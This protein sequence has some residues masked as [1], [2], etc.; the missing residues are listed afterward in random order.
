MQPTP[1]SNVQ[2][3]A[4]LAYD[5]IERVIHDREIRTRKSEKETTLNAKLNLLFNGWLLAGL[6]S[7]SIPIHAANGS[8]LSASEE[9]A[10][11]IGMSTSEVQ[12][13]LGRP[14]HAV[15]YG[16]APGPVWTYYVLGAPFG[17]T[18]FNIDF[19]PDGRVI[20]TSEYVVGSVGRP[21]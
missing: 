19:G 1:A 13:L 10:I 5:E 17:R 9:A 11:K 8:T 14:A 6:V 12:Q 20:S 4:L 18:E 16:N 7:S 3:T 15:K 21:N 2:G